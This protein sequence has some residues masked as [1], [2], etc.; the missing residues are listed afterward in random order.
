MA[1]LLVNSLLSLSPGLAC[2][3]IRLTVWC[4]YPP[5]WLDV[6]EMTL[7]SHRSHG[8][9]WYITTQSWFCFS[10][11]SDTGNTIPFFIVL[12]QLI[13]FFYIEIYTSD[14]WCRTTLMRWALASNHQ[15][16]MWPNDT[17]LDSFHSSSSW[18]LSER[19]RRIF[20]FCVTF[21]ILFPTIL[22]I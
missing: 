7:I 10:P 14:S 4:K 16:F 13:R 12:L 17:I 8:Q 19:Q 11:S 5:C 3:L 22:A 18:Y 2:H 9:Q 6:D 1:T 20:F 21:S 15:G